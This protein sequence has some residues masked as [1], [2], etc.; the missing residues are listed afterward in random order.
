[1][2]LRQQIV[3]DNVSTIVDLYDVPK[4]YAFLLFV[5]SLV[6]GQSINSLDRSDLVE[7][8]QDKQN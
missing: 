8:G 5:W 3:S 6:T 4:D 7:G 2:N 1:M